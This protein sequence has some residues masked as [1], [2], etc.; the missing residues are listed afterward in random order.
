MGLVRELPVSGER[1]VA[2]LFPEARLAA[3]VYF[4]EGP[5]INSISDDYVDLPELL[6]VLE[7]IRA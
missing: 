6:R 1:W 2:K 5:I 4:H 7:E 3:A